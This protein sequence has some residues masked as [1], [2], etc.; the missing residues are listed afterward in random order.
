MPV[1]PNP[2][3]QN[4]IDAFGY[5]FNIT[6]SK[7]NRTD[8]DQTYLEYDDG[9]EM[10]TFKIIRNIDAEIAESISSDKITLFASIF[11][12]KRVDY[13]G[14]YTQTIICPE[15]F[16][17]KYYELQNNKSARNDIG[18]ENIIKYFV[19]YANANK[20]AGACSA[21]LIQYRY[22]YGFMSCPQQRML[23]EIEYYSVLELNNTQQ[24]MQ[25]LN[26]DVLSNSSI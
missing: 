6:H 7:F 1:S 26:C 22:D 9:K 21:D 16:K 14:Q 24:F 11:E 18:N 12:P 20:V 5:R 8:F 3:T 13:P 17:P 2:Q 4:V 23:V 10:I 19:G 15:E 25:N